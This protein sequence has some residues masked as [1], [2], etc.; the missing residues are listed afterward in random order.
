MRVPTFLLL[1]LLSSLL[2]P[3]GAA[4][5]DDRAQGNAAAPRAPRK[6]YAFL[7]D[8]AAWVTKAF[9]QAQARL[10]ADDAPGAIRLLQEV[11][12]ERYYREA[13][14]AGPTAEGLRASAPNVVSVR[15][16]LVY[17]GAWI[18]ARHQ[19]ASL[20]SEAREVYRR[21]FGGAAQ[22][23]FDQ[24]L[25]R[26]SLE[27]LREVARR[28]LPLPAGKSAALM[29]CDLAL[30]RGDADEALEWLESLEDL[31]EVAGVRGE[32]E[33]AQRKARIRRHAWA[34]AGD[35]ASREAL[36]AALLASPPEAP[37]FRSIDPR[38][39]AVERTADAWRTSGGSASRAALPPALGAR[40]T[41]RWAPE[42]QLVDTAEPNPR[43]SERTS[44]LLPPRAATDGAHVFVSDG[45]ALFV[46]ALPS[47]KLVA[48]RTYPE[49]DIISLSMT[50]DRRAE[51]G[52]I[53]G[54]CITLV[55]LAGRQL[56]VVTI[57]DATSFE[58]RLLARSYDSE[59]ERRSDRL[60]AFWWDGTALD[61]A[62]ELGPDVE[63]DDDS[64]LTTMRLHGA[65]AF[66]RGRLWCSGL[67][68]SPA[69]KDQW[70]TWLVSVDPATGQ[71]LTATNTATGTPVRRGRF[72]EV[73][74]S[75]PTCARGRVVHTTSVGVVTAVDATDGRIRWAHRYDRDIQLEQER[76]TT[77][78][79][80]VGVRHAAF[81]NEPPL[82]ALGRVFV[83]PTD[84]TQLLILMNRPR[85]K[86]RALL[87]ATPG[88]TEIA[89]GFH[90]ETIIGLTPA[91][92]EAPPR[93][94]L[95]GRGAAATPPGPMT[96]TLGALD[97]TW[98]EHCWRAVD[99]T[100]LSEPFGRGLV[101]EG[102]IY[103]PTRAGIVV[104]DPATGRDL[105]VLDRTHIPEELRDLAA[106]MPYG[107]LIPV[108]GRG[109]VAV[110][111]TTISYWSK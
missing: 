54:H 24:A 99:P 20:P 7:H 56:V 2:V 17:E 42:G 1:I 34:L 44:V 101:T 94:V 76:R 23:A 62:W 96:V 8:S 65:P 88:R 25:E 12:D 86:E 31:E 70:E 14:A 85:L 82:Q 27:D 74:P 19:L 104:L 53:E 73:I 58:G 45:A 15:G 28:F 92:R 6:N 108:P 3:Q 67:R 49:G 9:K 11:V 37:D 30:E 81:H 59:P 84:G 51:L 22:S 32:D 110:S 47:G 79:H 64:L 105:A 90:A 40:L 87:V 21:E 35:P 68:S 111:A 69:S 43:Q 71:V 107:N 13:G 95:T 91:S 83:A 80:A 93:L 102:E 26:R 78:H 5:R 4:A 29:L 46:V 63:S 39:L 75:S 38:W 50:A 97:G 57:P 60:M 89:E 52:F 33:Q 10:D 66:Y 61:A 36:E 100:G 109:L 77:R 103:V 72:D 48:E 55:P 18:V 106:E 41:L 98:D 16:T